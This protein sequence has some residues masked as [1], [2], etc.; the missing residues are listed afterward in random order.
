MM[1]CML[2][3]VPFPAFE[4]FEDR[5]NIP[6]RY[7]LFFERILRPGRHNKELWNAA[8]T[9]KNGRNNIPF[10]SS[11]FEAH[12]LTTIRENYFTWMYQAL[13]NP[14][15]MPFL[16]KA[17]DFKVE[18]DFDILP[19]NLACNCAL[20]SDLPLS[21]EYRYNVLTKS[22]EKVCTKDIEL[23][24]TYQGVMI[25]GRNDENGELL[26]QNLEPEGEEGQAITDVQEELQTTEKVM[27]NV[28]FVKQRDRL[29]E[30]VDSD[31]EDR[32]KTLQ[33]L[34]EKVDRVRPGFTNYSRDQKS[35]FNLNAK[36]TFRKFMDNGTDDVVD[37]RTPP[38]KKPKKP[39]PNKCRIPAQKLDVLKE[40]NSV[41]LREKA[42]GL[43]KAWERFYKKTVNIRLQE[44]AKEYQG[45]HKTT[46]FL[47]ELE[48]LEVNWKN[49]DPATPETA[50]MSDLDEASVE[51]SFDDEENRNEVIQRAEV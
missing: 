48:D 42:S 2:N 46:D 5:Q 49:K 44:E 25:E 14:N 33:E 7:Y 27:K 1:E 18:Y 40:V 22:F 31:K 39:S 13:S 51:S 26:P 29:Q 45:N 19:E 37:G 47:E 21:S 41:I 16:K 3:K 28:I 11:I 8:I 20:I 30:L 43:R 38:T 15:V 34:R 17:K 4:T 50:D 35:Q 36:R 6:R 12:V 10:S 9:R 32:R 24:E 23:I